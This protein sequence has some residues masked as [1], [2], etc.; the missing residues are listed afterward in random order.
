MF[1]LLD[2]NLVNWLK[3]IV[4]PIIHTDVWGPSKVATL[5]GARWFIGFINDYMQ[6]MCVY[7]LKQKYDALEVSNDFAI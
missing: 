6:V 1:L 4:F 5:L 3:V 7:L 2:A